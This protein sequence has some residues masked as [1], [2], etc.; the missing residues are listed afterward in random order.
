MDTQEKVNSIWSWFKGNGNR[1]AGQR[2]IALEDLA[3]GKEETASMKEINK[4]L[5]WH[6]KMSGR[7]WEVYVGFAL[8]ILVQVITFVFQNTGG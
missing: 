5:V 8:V 6:E 2:L 4:H 3:H 7:R 1:G